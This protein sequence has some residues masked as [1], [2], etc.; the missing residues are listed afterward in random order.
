MFSLKSLE[1]VYDFLIANVDTKKYSHFDLRRA[2]MAKALSRIIAFIVMLFMVLNIFVYDKPLTAFIEAIASMVA[3]YAMSKLKNKETFEFAINLSSANIFILMLVYIFLNKNDNFALIWTIAIP[4]FEIYLNGHKKGLIISAI[5]Y[6]II[7]IA[8]YMGIGSW[9]NEAWD[10]HSYIQFVTASLVF[11]CI[12]YIDELS[13]YKTYLLLEEKEKA[14]QE[15]LEK[16]KFIA[17]RDHLTKLYNRRKINEIL[18][19]EIKKSKRYDYNFC[20]AILDMDFFK[21]VNDTYGHNVG[22]EVLVE[23]AELI[24][25]KLRDTDFV[26]RWGGEEF[27]IIFTHTDMDVA[28]HKCEKIRKDILK[29]R[30]SKEK[31]AL[32]CSIGL[33]QPKEEDSE[34]EELIHRADE[35]LYEAKYS[36]RNCVITSK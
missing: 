29:S 32:T 15:N 1:K 25:K 7:F 5:F 22:D 2:M 13:V 4:I 14:E 31:I 8:S 27:I 24:T 33:A 9:Q 21:K 23:F 16:L 10:Q 36:G 19:R 3:I 30:F 11:L 28:Y 18:F 26:G 17:D 20:I 35:A 12:I 6:T 34:I